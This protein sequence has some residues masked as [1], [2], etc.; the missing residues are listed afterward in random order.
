MK[1]KH[2]IALSGRASIGKTRT[3][4]M[5]IDMLN[6]VELTYEKHDTR[7][8]CHYHGKTICVTTPGDN[9]WEISK[10]IDYINSH[11]CDIAVMATRTRGATITTLTNYAEQ[12]DAPIHWIRKAYETGDENTIN[13]R[14]AQQIVDRVEETITIL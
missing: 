8:T 6:G 4:R 12:I 7:T 14:Y 11:P 13:E 10:N 5:V 3:L 2:I 1:P 9:G